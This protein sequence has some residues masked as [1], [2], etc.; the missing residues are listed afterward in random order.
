V[1][2][3]DWSLSRRMLAGSEAAFEEF[4][5]AYFPA[6]CRFAVARMRS[7]P[8]AVEDV[9]QATLTRAVSKLSSYRGEAA[10]L[11]WL[12]T[13]CRHEISAH[14]ERTSRR[15]DV[16][17]LV[18]ESREV[19][20]ALESLRGAAGIDP[21]SSL[22]RK[23]I[24]RLVHLV[25]D[26]LPRRYADALEWKYS[27]LIRVDEIAQRLS[28]SPKAAESLLTRAR[29]A[30]RD[31]FITLSHSGGAAWPEPRSLGLRNRA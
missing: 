21:E 5:E 17:E 22:A 19:L 16:V 31:A 30:F 27:E 1:K 6:L 4:F 13:F 20:A 18:E 12:C 15:S 10:L 29:E 28:V 2:N 14:F 3:E 8:E 7:D 9:V 26:R 11:T 25:L 24:G 23:E